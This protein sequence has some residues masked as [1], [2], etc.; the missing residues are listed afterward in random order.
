MKS[1]RLGAEGGVKTVRLSRPLRLVMPPLLLSSLPKNA[2]GFS[3]ESGATG[4]IVGGALVVASAAL[5]VILYPQAGLVGLAISA[6]LLGTTGVLLLYNGS[7]RV[8]FVKSLC[9]RCR[10]LPVI[11]EHEAIH[12]GG[13]ESDDEVWRLI[14]RR[15]SCESLA[16]EGDSAIC[17]FCPIPKRLSEH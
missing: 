3:F 5:S 1:A 7:N 15:H 9:S 16:L 12:L 14:R 10:L 6:W 2:I 11:Q 4:M 17:S 13:V 8:A